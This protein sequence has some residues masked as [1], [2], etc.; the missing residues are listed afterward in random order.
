VSKHGVTEF[1]RVF[2]D[3]TTVFFNIET[4][5]LVVLDENGDI[6][7]VNPAFTRNLGYEETDVLRMPIIRLVRSEDWSAFLN[8]FTA[9]E[10]KPF[11]MLHQGEGEITVRLIAVRFKSGRGFI[12]L[13]K[14]RI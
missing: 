1:L 13:R 5:L 4:D 12:V 9:P 3:T 10:P 8:A 2:E 11:R 6:N 7:R 14:M